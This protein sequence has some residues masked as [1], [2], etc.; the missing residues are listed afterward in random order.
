MRRLSEKS[1]EGL[2]AEDI[3]KEVDAARI[4]VPEMVHAR[5]VMLVSEPYAVAMDGV[6]VAMGAVVEVV[7]DK[8]NRFEVTGVG[9]RVDDVVSNRCVIAAS[10]V[11]ADIAWV[12]NYVVLDEYKLRCAA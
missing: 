12:D 4:C 8:P 1:V 10:D 7:D 5:S 2:V 3:V 11:D 9:A 6:V